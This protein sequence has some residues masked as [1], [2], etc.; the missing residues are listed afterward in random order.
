M[1]DIVGIEV[2]KALIGEQSAEEAVE[3]INSKHTKLLRRNG[4]LK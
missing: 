3:A 2:N 4:L 1:I